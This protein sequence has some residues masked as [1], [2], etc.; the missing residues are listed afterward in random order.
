MAMIVS[1]DGNENV[2]EIR[3]LTRSA[4]E[5]K[6]LFLVPHM[7]PRAAMARII[8]QHGSAILAQAEPPV[9][10]VG[11]LVALLAVH[12]AETL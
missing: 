10:I 2:A 8:N 11:T 4:P 12:A 5:T 9:V 7:P 1:L 6:F 3:G